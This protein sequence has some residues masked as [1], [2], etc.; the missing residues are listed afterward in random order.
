MN[1]TKAKLKQLR[2]KV[3][4]ARDFAA[5]ILYFEDGESERKD[6]VD[7]VEASLQCLLDDLDEALNA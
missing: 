2:S 6:I 4:K 7:D 3:E 5:D 1:I